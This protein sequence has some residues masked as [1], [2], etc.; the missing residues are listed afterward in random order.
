VMR[1]FIAYID[2][3]G[4]EGFG[5]LKGTP[6]VGGQS[7]WLMIGACVAR[8]QDDP[9]LSKWRDDILAQF[10]KSKKR[11]LHFRDLNH[12]QRLFVSQQIGKHPLGVAVT[13]SHKVT[14]PGSSWAGVFK[15]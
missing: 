10:P 3:A 13:C 12:D 5:K 4:D 11:D 9:K 15:Q 8:G 2:E 7:R 14:I 1:E 6:S